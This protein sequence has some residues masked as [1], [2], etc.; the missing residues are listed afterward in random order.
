[1]EMYMKTYTQQKVY[2]RTALQLKGIFPNK[3]FIFH[4]IR[5]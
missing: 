2:M 1:M 3:K 5:K 4:N